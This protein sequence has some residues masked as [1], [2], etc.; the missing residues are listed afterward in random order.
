MEKPVKLSKIQEKQQKEQTRVKIYDNLL[1]VFNDEIITPTEVIIIW[2][3]RRR[4]KSS[5]AGWFMSEFMKPYIAKNDVRTSTYICDKLNDAGFNIR[6]PNDHTVFCDTFFE[7]PGKKSVSAYKCRALDFGLP[8]DTHPTALLCPCGRYFFD[9][10]QVIFNSHEGPPPL[11]VSQC[12]ELSGQY[13]LFLSFILQRPIRIPKDIRELAVFMEVVKM[14]NKYSEYGILIASY[15]IV[16]IIYENAKLEEYTRTRD[17]K[18]IDKV[19]IFKFKGNIFKCYDSYYFLP[20]FVRGKEN[21]GLV[22]EKTQR[23]QFSQEYFEEYYKN[24]I[25]DIPDSYRG[26]N[27]NKEKKEKE[28]AN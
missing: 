6:P 27:K 9:E 13:N 14:K 20:M 11:F 24:R 16:N 21:E 5:L 23:T 17:P 12:I 22:L 26:K 8:N 2:G 19:V 18:L 4:G 15:W 28:S 3:R 1:D 7:I 10:S 25:I